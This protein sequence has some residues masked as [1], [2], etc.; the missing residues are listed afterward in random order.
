MMEYME[1]AQ[2]EVYEYE[3]QNAHEQQN[4]PQR[5]TQQEDE[6]Q[7]GILDETQEQQL[8]NTVN[9]VEMIDENVI[10]SSLGKHKYQEAE[11]IFR[12][13]SKQIIFTQELETTTLSILGEQKSDLLQQITEQQKLIEDLDMIMNLWRERRSIQTRNPLPT[14][15]ILGNESS[16]LS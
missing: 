3:Q 5:G 16:S 4:A 14:Q 10:E 12:E 2:N 1:E 7:K 6:A 13:E 9:D 8:E 11:A 15:R